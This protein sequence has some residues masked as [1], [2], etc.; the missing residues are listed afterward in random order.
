MPRLR[1]MQ[2]EVGRVER[3]LAGLVDHRLA[4]ERIELGDDVVAGL[5][6]DQDAAHRPGVADAHRGRAAL[7]LGRRRIGE[8]RAVAFARV[9]DQ[10]ACGARRV[11]HRFAGADR[12]LQ[13]RHVVAER[14]AEAARLEKVALHVDD[15]ERGPFELDGERL[16]L[17]GDLRYHSAA[18]A[19]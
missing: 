19:L 8:I 4:V 13:Q 6:A 7:D 9:D 14:F 10:Q 11:E 17:G 3:A 5:A 12:G 16:R 18:R 1:S 2:L 15:D